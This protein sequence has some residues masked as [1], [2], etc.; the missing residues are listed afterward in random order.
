MSRYEIGM[1]MCEEN[2]FEYTSSL[3]DEISQNNIIISWVN[4]VT[5][6]IGLNVVREDSEIMDLDLSN[7]NSLLLLLGNDTHFGVHI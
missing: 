2:V 6:L 3:F 5:F 1:I 7:K 4:D